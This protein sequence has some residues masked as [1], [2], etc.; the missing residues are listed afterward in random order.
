MGGCF[1]ATASLD[2]GELIAATP[3]AQSIYAFPQGVASA[4]PQP[5]AIMF[6][7]RAVGEGAPVA[8][9]ALRLQISTDAQFQGG[10]VDFE[11]AA[12]AEDD[13]TVRA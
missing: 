13:F 12:K 3:R 7:T 6:W 10:V 11:V 1:A 8:R 9:I 2:V 4:D 5:D